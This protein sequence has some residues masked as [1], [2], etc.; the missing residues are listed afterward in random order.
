[1]WAGLIIGMVIGFIGEMPLNFKLSKRIH[2]NSF[3][4]FGG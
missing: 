4:P 2:S 3:R 1:M